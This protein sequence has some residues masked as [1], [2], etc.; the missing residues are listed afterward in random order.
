MN[1]AQNVTEIFCT[2]GMPEIS[3]LIYWVEIDEVTSAIAIV[4]L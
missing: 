2:D 3:L 4:V 1:S